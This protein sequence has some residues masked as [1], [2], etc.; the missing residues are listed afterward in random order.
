[1]KTKQPKRRVFRDCDPALKEARRRGLVL[2]VVSARR[3][4]EVV[5]RDLAEHRCA[6]DR[7]WLVFD[8]DA[9]KWIGLE[10]VQPGSRKRGAA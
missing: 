5:E 9:D 2:E 1:M 4:R 10:A 8:Q 7:K 3:S 6:C